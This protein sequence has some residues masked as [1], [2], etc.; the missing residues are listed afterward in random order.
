MMANTKGLKV[1]LSYPADERASARRLQQMLASTD[2]DIWFDEQSLVPGSSWDS[3]IS[4]AIDSADVVLYLLG[5]APASKSQTLELRRALARNRHSS[6]PKV[7]PVF[8]P[9]SSP[10]DLPLALRTVQGIDLREGSSAHVQA[11]RLAAA[12]SEDD[13]TGD[14]AEPEEVGDRLRV[15]GDPDGAIPWYEKA[16]KV[17][18]ANL[19]ARHPSVAQLH[20]KLGAVLVDVARLEEAEARFRQALEVDTEVFGPADSIVAADRTNLA[21]VAMRTGRVEEALDLLQSTVA[22]FRRDSPVALAAMSNMSAALGRLGRSSEA[23]ELAHTV[24][25]TRLR[26]LGPD[27]PESLSSANNYAATLS[28][29]GRFEEATR[30]LERTLEGRERVLGPNHPSTLSTLS[31]LA[32]LYTE[33][34][35]LLDARHLQERVFESLLSLYGPHHGEVAQ[36]ANNLAMTHARSGD[37]MRARELLEL[38]RTR[39]RGSPSDG[40]EI[41]A[42]TANLGAVLHALGDEDQAMQ[43]FEEA[44]QTYTRLFGAEHSTTK[45]VAAAIESL[46]S[47]SARGDG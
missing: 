6:G 35:R 39:V 46:G 8:L 31:N 23:S 18:E 16:L 4:S 30:V 44:L 32:T 47:S 21:T 27:H 11:S 5:S 12:L 41:A 9:G 40:P 24:Y 43:L 38:A 15:G 42:A 33:Q 17:A 10:E 20:R 14:L 2:V 13:R 7:I 19:G 26:T 28:D 1:F 25:E 45:R 36:A 29:L 34:G 22:M 3:A 37:Y